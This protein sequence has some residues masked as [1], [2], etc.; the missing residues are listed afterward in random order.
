MNSVWATILLAGAGTYAM[1]ASFIAGMIAG[2]V[3][4]RTTSVAATLILGMGLVVVL[5]NL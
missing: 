4:W 3:A 2:L 5:Q 1:R